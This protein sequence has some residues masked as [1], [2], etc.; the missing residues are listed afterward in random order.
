MAECGQGYYQTAGKCSQ[1]P[2]TCA[3]C[4]SRLNCTS[5]A[6]S[7]RLQSGT[8]RAICA[9][10]YYPD[11][12]TCSKCYLS[13]ETC[14][15]PRRD[16]CASCPPDWRLAAGECR[17]E[18]PQNFFPWEDSCRRCHHYC[19]DCHGA[20]PQ[21]CTSCPP[22]FSLEGGLCVECLSSQ[23]YEPRT[24]TCRPCHDSCRSCSGPGP[25]S[26]VTCAHPLRLDRWVNF[27][28]FS[29]LIITLYNYGSYNIHTV[30]LKLKV[31]VSKLEVKYN[32]KKIIWYNFYYPVLS[33]KVNVGRKKMTRTYTF[34]L[35]FYK[36]LSFYVMN[37]DNF[38][39]RVNHKCLP[40]CTESMASFY[41]NLNQTTD[42]CHCDKDIGESTMNILDIIE[43]HLKKMYF[44][45][46]S[47]N[48]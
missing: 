9:P 6:G 33:T 18:C 4:V 31:L 7:L 46:V 30:K 17:P 42:C 11:E 37:N 38:L 16:Q 40:C 32:E 24:R 2:H 3:T 15:G 47:Y 5:C 25:T 48:P 28:Y 8:C 10:G 12:G 13:C 1:C 21:R 39:Y 41:L 36:V 44:N 22:H 34:I 19:Q 29:Q 14:T 23:Y 43:I 27:H 35:V 45:N 26:C 20:G